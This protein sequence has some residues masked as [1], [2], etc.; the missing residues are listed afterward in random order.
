MFATLGIVLTFGGGALAAVALARLRR[1]GCPGCGAVGSLALLTASVDEPI[2]GWASVTRTFRCADCGAAVR[3]HHPVSS[4][5]DRTRP[6]RIGHRSP[7][8]VP[9]VLPPPGPTP[10]VS[11]D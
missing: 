11:T 1:A 8:R 9:A 10:V 6:R 5:H 7:R 4:A 3:E 2:D